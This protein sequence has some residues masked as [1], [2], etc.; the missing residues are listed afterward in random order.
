[1]SR[2]P[3]ASPSCCS[4]TR[5]PLPLNGATG[6]SPSRSPRSPPLLLKNEPLTDCMPSLVRSASRP[7]TETNMSSSTV[8]PRLLS[9]ISFPPV[10]CRRRSTKTRYGLD[11]CASAVA[12]SPSEARP[13][14]RP[15]GELNI[16]TP[17][18]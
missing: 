1:M 3:S 7:K 6:L 4:P 18:S 13:T 14:A 16:T 9:V 8:S 11:V 10:S 2:S 15:R 17:M 5:D 12:D